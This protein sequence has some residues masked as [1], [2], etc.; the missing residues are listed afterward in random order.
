MPRR[1]PQSSP[2]TSRPRAHHPRSRGD[3]AFTLVEL[4]V[5]IGIIALLVSILL[6]TLNKARA[7]ALRTACL[8]NLRQV[9]ATLAMYAEINRDYVP[10]GYRDGTPPGT[11]AGTKQFNSMVYSGTTGHLVI[12]GLLLDSGF[13]RTPQMFYCPAE[14]DPSRQ[15]N[16]PENPFPTNLSYT[17]TSNTQ[18][19]YASRPSNAIPDDPSLWIGATL[20]K[21]NNFGHVTLL[22]DLTTLPTR[23]ATRHRT[24]INALSAD[25]SAKW[26]PLAVFN[27]PLSQ[28]T[29]TSPTFNPQQDAIWSSLDQ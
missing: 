15:Y 8:S 19:G 16:T 28:C 13:L 12:F 5:V 26:Y 18:A 4:L 22:S 6:P 29:G 21:L 7:A 25:G 2:H 14:N 23:V 20:P 17:S 10:V 24:G 3:L 27:T 11:G 1:T 9:H